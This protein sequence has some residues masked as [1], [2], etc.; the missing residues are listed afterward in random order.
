MFGHFCKRASFVW[1][2]QRLIGTA[3]LHVL[4]L[5]RTDEAKI[6]VCSEKKVDIALSNRPNLIVNSSILQI[7]FLFGGKQSTFGT[8]VETYIPV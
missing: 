3:V 6:R 4:P 1:T 2:I 8:Y 5:R 7:Y